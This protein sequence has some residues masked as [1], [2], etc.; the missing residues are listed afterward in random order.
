[1][2]TGKVNNVRRNP[3]IKGRRPDRKEA[4]RAAAIARA[5]EAKKHLYM[6][7]ADAR[8][9]RITGGKSAA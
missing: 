1:M 2:G 3:G 4:R 6:S 7:E 9:Y 8:L 5:P